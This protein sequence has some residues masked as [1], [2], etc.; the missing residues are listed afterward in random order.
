[1]LKNLNLTSAIEDFEFIPGISES[2]KKSWKLL[3]KSIDFIDQFPAKHQKRM[4]FAFDEF[5]DISKLDGD[6]IIKP[7]RSTIQMHKNAS[8]IFSESCRLRR[9][10]PF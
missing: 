7:F 5:G 8:Y 2:Q 6:K 9:F 4:I 10:I 1:M 3:E